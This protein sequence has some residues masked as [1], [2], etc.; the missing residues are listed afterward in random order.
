[1]LTAER[2][3]SFTKFSSNSRTFLLISRC[4]FTISIPA[5]VYSGVNIP[6]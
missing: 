6:W 2:E 1:M 4:C 5:A 3:L